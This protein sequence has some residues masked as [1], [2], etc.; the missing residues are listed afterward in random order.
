VV[1]KISI[2]SSEVL[3][4]PGV[5]KAYHSIGISWGTWQI[6]VI[7]GDA[8]SLR[9]PVDSFCGTQSL[10]F[11]ITTPPIAHHSQKMTLNLNSIKQ[12]ALNETVIWEFSPFKLQSD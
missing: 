4:A 12:V 3:P 11:L 10:T 6:S 9:Y 2:V 1:V 7:S 5:L 8:E